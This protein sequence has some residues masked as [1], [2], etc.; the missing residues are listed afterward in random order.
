[1]QKELPSVSVILPVKNGAAYLAESLQ[2]VTAQEHPP[3][4]ILVF[5]NGSAD[6]SSEIAASFPAVQIFRNDPGLSI[7]AARNAGIRA[8][9]GELLAFAS[10]DDLWSPDKLRLQA[11]RFAESS[12]LDFCVAHVRCFLDGELEAAPAGLPADRVGCDLPGWLTETLVARRRAFDHVGYFD[13]RMQQADDTDWLARARD[14]GLRWEMMA[15][16]LVEKRLHGANITYREETRT[17]GNA[18]MIEIAR[19]AIARKR[20]G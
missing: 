6:A 15:E 9:R 1:M 18:E 13:E 12:E 19:R 7:A 10:H 2:S 8:A 14:A 16:T 17:R 4:E 3:L 11:T 5:D 20:E